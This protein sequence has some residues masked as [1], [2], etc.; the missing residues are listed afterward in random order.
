MTDKAYRIYV[1][2]C[3]YILSKTQGAEMRHRYADLFKPQDTRTGDEIAMDIITRAGL[4]I[5]GGD[6]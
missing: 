4:Q 6:T 5:E 2:D 1:T 3:L